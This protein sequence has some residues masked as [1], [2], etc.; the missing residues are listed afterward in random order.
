VQPVLETLINGT[1]NH[2][3][4]VKALVKEDVHS[5]GRESYLRAVVV[6]E[7]GKYAAS[8]A[9]HQGSGNLFSIVQANSL[10]V[11]PAGVKFCPTGSEVEA[12]LLE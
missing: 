11:I 6:Y 8:L 9:G 7:N 10:L 2:Q 4:W 12:W 3:R 5:D 1:V